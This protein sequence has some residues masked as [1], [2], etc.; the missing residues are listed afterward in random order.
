MNQSKVV[1]VS[2]L[3]DQQKVTR[4]QIWVVVLCAFSTLVDG[5]DAVA[6]GYVAPVVSKLWRLPPGA[7]KGECPSAYSA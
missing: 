7:F 1:D 5:F 3:I 4:F 2:E 6:I